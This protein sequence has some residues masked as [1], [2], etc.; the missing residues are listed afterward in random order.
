MELVKFI[1]KLVVDA[2]NVQRRFTCLDI[3]KNKQQI[4]LILTG[5]HAIK[6]E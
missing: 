2:R 1:D 3:Q 5:I 6:K 4:E